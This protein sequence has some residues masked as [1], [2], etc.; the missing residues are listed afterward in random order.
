MELLKTYLEGLAAGDAEKVA[1]LFAEDAVFYDEGPMKMDRPP[2]TIRGRQNIR[3][4]FQQVFSSQGPIKA[5]NVNINGN[6]MRY[7]V[8]FGDQRIL[9]LGLLT[10]KE[11]LIAEY[12]V[13]V[14]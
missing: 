7:D 10:E 12:R 13:T 6:A 1:L 3:T 8:A 11:G 5:F 14:V 9:A 4:F 2:L